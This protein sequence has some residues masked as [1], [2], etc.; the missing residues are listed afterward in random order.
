MLPQSTAGCLA[1]PS[2]ADELVLERLPNGE[3]AWLRPERPP[4]RFVLTNSK[5]AT[6]TVKCYGPDPTDAATLAQLLVPARRSGQPGLGHPTPWPA[7]PGAASAHGAVLAA[8]FA[9]FLLFGLFARVWVDRLLR[10]PTLVAATSLDRASEVPSCRQRRLSHIDILIW[11][12]LAAD[13]EAADHHPAHLQ[14]EAPTNQ[15]HVRNIGD[16]G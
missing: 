14:G 5:G 9:P 6:W 13:A 12:A 11:R 8:R 4:E 1:G 15:G 10:R 2:P 16:A 3:L 7:W